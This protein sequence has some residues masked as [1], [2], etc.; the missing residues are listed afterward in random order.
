MAVKNTLGPD[1][2]IRYM[3][4]SKGSI[5]IFV[6]IGSTYILVSRYKSFVE[7]IDL[8]ISQFKGIVGKY[9]I[10]A[11]ALET[12]TT[13]QL[14][15]GIGDPVASSHFLSWHRNPQITTLLMWYV[16]ISHAVLLLAVLYLL[17]I[18][19]SP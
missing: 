5:E 6:I 3:A 12:E 7:S 15:E 17:L 4:I 8:L 2:E 10:T 9:A 16:L 18:G 11:G 13:W 19:N 1:F 14:Q